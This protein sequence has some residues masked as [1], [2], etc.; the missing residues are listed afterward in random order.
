MRLVATA[1]INVDFPEA[2]E[3]VNKI[4]C[5]IFKLFGTASVSN[6]CNKLL[7]VICCLSLIIDGSQY[8]CNVRRYITNE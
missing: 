6:G 4:L 5:F 2:F 1:F 7:N 8:V 3:P